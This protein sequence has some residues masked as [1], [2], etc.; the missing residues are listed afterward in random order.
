MFLSCRNFIKTMLNQ[1]LKI[2]FLTAKDARDKKSWSGTDYYIV[3]ALEQYCGEVVCFGPVKPFTEKVGRRV[4]LVLEKVLKKTYSPDRSLI[5]SSHYA[6]IFE[7]KLAEQPVD[8]IFA[9]A[10]STE[11][12]RLK[13]S[14]PIIYLSDATFAL[15]N[16]YYADFSNMMRLSKWNSNILER[17]AIQKASMLIYSSAWAANSAV[18][19][20]EADRSKIHVLPFGANLDE[21]PSRDLVLSKQK[22]ERCRLLFLGVSWQRKGGDIAFETLLELE[23]LGLDAEL[24]ICGCIPPAEFTHPRMT[25][26]PFLDK[27]DPVQYQQLVELLLKSNFLL[28]PTRGDCTPIVFS[29]A[30]AFGLPV[31]TTDTG[32]VSGVV[33]EGENGCMLPIEARGDQYAQ[34]I[35]DIYQ[36][37]HQYAELVRSSRAAFD[38]RLNWQT[39]GMT[40]N[41]LIHDHFSFVRDRT[42]VPDQPLTADV[43]L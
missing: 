25:V 31:I 18:K 10:A 15:I 41:K 40:M 27:N 11:I 34:L 8:L 26:V 39:W 29:E 6:K 35:Y 7:R 4:S 9:S 13:T 24:I 43:S 14:I 17:L 21:A 3:K 28:L 32:G 22:T 5:V 20:Y 36:N 42:L 12:A 33:S 38:N 30:N 1:P 23:K 2:G 19:D 37:D 16:N